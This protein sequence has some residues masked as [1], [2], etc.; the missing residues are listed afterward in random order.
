MRHFS[1]NGMSLGIHR[2]LPLD[3]PIGEPLEHADEQVLDRAEVVV[4]QAV[5]EP[6]LLGEPSRRDPA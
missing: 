1:M 3:Q 2:A 6:G 5:V 4:H